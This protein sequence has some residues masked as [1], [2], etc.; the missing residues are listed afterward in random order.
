LYW[1]NH[2]SGIVFGSEAK[3][4]F[5]M[6]VPKDFD[7][8]TWGELLVF[9]FV[10]GSATPFKGVHRLL[11]GHLLKWKGGRSSIERWWNLSQRAQALSGDAR[12]SDAIERFRST[13]DDAVA[14]RRISDVPLGVMLSGGLDSSSVATSLSMQAGEG[15]N[16]FTVRFDEAG[17]DEGPVAQ[18]VVSACGLRHHDI[19]VTPEDLHAL[20]FQ[21]THYF[22]E[23]LV[24]GND[25]HM[26]ALAFKAKQ[27]VTVLLSGEGADETLN[28]YVRY[29]PFRLPQLWH[30]ARWS[31]PRLSQHLGE[32]RFAKRV[33]KM[34]RFLELPS[35]DEFILYNASD[36]LPSQLSEF[37]FHV[38]DEFQYRR[39]VL[40]EAQSYSEQPL[41]Q[42]MYLDQHTF[43]VSLL[44]RNDRMTMG[45]SIECR[46]PFLDYRLVEYL[47]ALP[48]SKLCPSFSRKTVQRA[49]KWGFGVPWQRYFREVPMFRDWA[50][51]LESREPVASGPLDRLKVRQAVQEYLAGDSKNEALI[52]MLFMLT[53]WHDVQFKSVARVAA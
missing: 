19:R 3:A 48:T 9:R 23:P 6:G 32:G 22:D 45:A 24:H 38:D 8:S 31:L 40:K 37:G 41:R 30:P 20:I 13:F 43:L 49:P 25:S 47:A 11:P 14:L 17:Y 42:A 26:L 29:Q 44:D 15:V 35:I 4:L 28:G 51:G 50:E 53:V 12:K 16:S 1:A 10:A 27:N 5:A 2:D 39:R 33:D 36:L 18:S 7:S 52:K 46:V 34:R 21:A